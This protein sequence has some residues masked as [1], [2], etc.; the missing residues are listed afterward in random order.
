MRGWRSLFLSRL[1][2]ANVAIAAIGLKIAVAVVPRWSVGITV[3]IS[4][5]V[6]YV[7]ILHVSVTVGSITVCLWATCALA[8]SVVPVITARS[9]VIVA[10]SCASLAIVVV[11]TA[12][13]RRT[14]AAARRA[15]APVTSTSVVATATATSVTAIAWSIGTWVEAPAS[16]WWCACPLNLQQVIAPDALVVHL[17]VSIISVPAIF[18]LNEG[19]ESARCGPWCWYVAADKSAISFEFVGKIACACAMTEAT[20]IESG[21]AA[22][23]RHRS[24]V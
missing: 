21:T 13:W 10:V 11:A 18:V 5:L 17:V 20:D 16:R 24:R 12:S 7:T 4:I 15:L 23:R 2:L 9:T 6:A 1:L 14:R 8:A 3:A 22:A 19:K